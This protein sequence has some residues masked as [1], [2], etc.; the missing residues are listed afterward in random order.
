MDPDACL[1]ALLD[2]FRDGDREAAYQGLEDLLDWCS[3]GGF[4]PKDPRLDV[5][6]E[7]AAATAEHLR[8][9]AQVLI[10]TAENYERA[11]TR[12]K[13]HTKPG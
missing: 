1:R 3:K 9:T 4:L 11:V 13:E 7:A 10:K 8:L 5:G 12:G 2:A 6:L